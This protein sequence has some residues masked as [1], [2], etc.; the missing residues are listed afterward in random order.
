MITPLASS[1][2]STPGWP[3]ARD[4]PTFKIRT[5]LFS[6]RACLTSLH[7][8][9]DT[10]D[11]REV[12]RYLNAEYVARVV[13]TMKSRSH[14]SMV[15]KL[16]SVRGRL[17]SIEAGRR[18]RT[19][20]DISRYGFPEKDHFRFVLA[21]AVSRS[22]LCEILGLT[23]EFCRFSIRQ[24]G[25]SGTT[26]SSY[27]TPSKATCIVPGISMDWVSWTDG[28]L[29]HHLDLSWVGSLSV[30]HRP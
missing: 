14:F 2:F 23:T 7:R 20:F 1:I 17:T 4:G 16:M 8:F 30:Q 15:V 10:Y 27:E 24:E 21:R 19:V 6:S 5:G 18:L 12:N 25:Q 3:S 11:G 9:W 22:Y 29:H 13:P 28:Y 26:K